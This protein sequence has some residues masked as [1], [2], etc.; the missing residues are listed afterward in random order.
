MEEGA[1]EAGHPRAPGEEEGGRLDPE[2]PTCDI[3]GRPMLDRHC[4]LICLNC[5]YRRDCSD[6]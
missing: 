3:C 2:G 6:P 1:S 5:G 4:K